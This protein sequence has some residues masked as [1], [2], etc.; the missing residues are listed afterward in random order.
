MRK[1]QLSDVIKGA[2]IF[3]GVSAPGVLTADMVRSMNKEPMIFA[4]A[5][6]IPE[7]YPEEA[8][9]GGAKVIGTGRS[10]FPNQINNVLAFPGIFRGALD[11]RA[12]Q[13]NEE[14][15]LAAAEAIAGVITDEELNEEYLLPAA[16]DLRVTPRVAAAVAEAAIKSGVARRKDIT[17]EWVFNHAKELVEVR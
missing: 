7:I 9:K 1:G 6:P 2:D 8:K 16:F 4:M 17:P 13:I 3:I 11:V 10:D 5:N 12:S 15:K 14:M